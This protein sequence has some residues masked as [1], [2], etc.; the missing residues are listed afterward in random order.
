MP[1]RRPCPEGPGCKYKD[2][3]QHTLEFSHGEESDKL[4]GKEAKASAWKGTNGL[5][6]VGSGRNGRGGSTSGRRKGTNNSARYAAGEAAAQRAAAMLQ[7]HQA[8]S[9]PERTHV[10]ATRTSIE[11][12]AQKKPSKRAKTT[13]AVRDAKKWN[14][15]ACTLLNEPLAE[16]CSICNS[17]RQ[18]QAETVGDSNESID[19]GRTRENAIDL[20][21]DSDCD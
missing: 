4:A 18:H 15:S 21:D 19:S 7:Q 8:T 17:L 5:T 12:V 20:A 13:G 6:L 10:A 2:E 11:S 14:C 3:H 9:Q 1:R 16:R